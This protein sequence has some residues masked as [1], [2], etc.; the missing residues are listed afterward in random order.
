M[1]S[2]AFTDILCASSATRDRLRHR[3][4]ATTCEPARRRDLVAFVVAMAV[5]R[6]SAAAPSRCAAAPAVS[7]PRSLS[8]RRRAASSGTPG[9]ATS[10][11]SSRFSPGFAAGRCSVPSF[12]RP[13]FSRRAFAFASAA[14]ARA[15]ASA[16]AFAA[17][18]AR[19]P[20]CVLRAAF[21]VLLRLDVFLL[22]RDSSCALRDFLL[23]RERS[24]SATARTPARR[25]AGAALP[26]RLP[27]P[28]ARSPASARRRRRRR[29]PAR[30][31]APARSPRTRRGSDRAPAPRPRGARARASCAPRPGSCATCRSSRRR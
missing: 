12:A 17:A 22:A 8:A 10:S 4:F 23:A 15:A 18:F 25:R 7:P 29:L 21:E 19:A 26:A 9:P 3:H 2:A 16:A 14:L 6:P 30:S 13:A 1:T 20:P 24:F 28:A 27:R 31:P 5:D 11:S